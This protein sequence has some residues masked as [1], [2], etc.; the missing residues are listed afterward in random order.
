[1]DVTI[2]DLAV[3]KEIVYNKSSLNIVDS[4]LELWWNK[5]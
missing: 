3:Y 2:N 1:M 4:L 5:V